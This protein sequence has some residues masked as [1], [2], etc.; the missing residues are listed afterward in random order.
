MVDLQDG[1]IETSAVLGHRQVD[2]IFMHILPLQGQS[3]CLP[4]ARKQE[5]LTIGPVNRIGDIAD[6]APP[7]LEI[8]DRV[9]L[10]PF[11]IPLNGTVGD[12]G[13][14]YTRRAWFQTLRKYFRT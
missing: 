14:S 8:F 11:L 3:L 6:L 4:D 9:P 5:L 2:A 13:K 1:E 12:S 10:R 7:S